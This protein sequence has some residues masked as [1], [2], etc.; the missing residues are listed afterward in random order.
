[1]P[2]L[3]APN[4][5][6]LVLAALVLAAPAAAQQTPAP[7]AGQPSATASDSAPLPAEFVRRRQAGRGWFATREQI[8]RRHPAGTLN[9][10]SAA[11]GVRLVS[12]GSGGMRVQMARSGHAGRDLPSTVSSNRGMLPEDGRGRPDDGEPRAVATGTARTPVG[13]PASG[14]DDE[15]RVQYFRNGVRFIPERESYISRDI[16][17]ASV[18]AVEIYRTPTETPPELR[19]AGADCGV[20]VIWTSAPAIGG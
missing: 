15:C 6:L 11:S 13:T 20:I 19:V 7:P 1:M 16:P 4:L 12:D 17:V 18:E 3:R 2:M 8:A 10:F 14:D 5:P 9:I